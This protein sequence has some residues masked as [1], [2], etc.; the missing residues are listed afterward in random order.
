M[1]IGLTLRCISRKAYAALISELVL[2]IPNPDS[3]ILRLLVAAAALD[4][5][6]QVKRRHDRPISRHWIETHSRRRSWEASSNG[7]LV[8][9]FQSIS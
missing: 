5:E 8:E 4:E 1:I 9:N 7:L 6:I 2:G 3:L